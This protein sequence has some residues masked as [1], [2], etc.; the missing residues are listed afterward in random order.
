[1]ETVIMENNKEFEKHI[2][3][4]FCFQINIVQKV[5]H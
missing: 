1:M 3:K 4:T 5:T 2:F